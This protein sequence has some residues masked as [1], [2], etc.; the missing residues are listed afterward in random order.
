MELSPEKFLKAATSRAK[1]RLLFV[2]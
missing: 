1:K 2:Y